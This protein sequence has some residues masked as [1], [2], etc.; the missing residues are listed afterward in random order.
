MLCATATPERILFSRDKMIYGHFLEHFHRQVYGG[1]FMPGHPLSDKDG[2]RTDV[3]DALRKIQTPIIR[4]P[5]GCFVSSYHW[6][7]GVGK[8]I[9]VFD[10]AW[11]V[12][13]DNSFG[14]DEFILLCRKI[15]CEPYICTNAGSGNEE[16]MSNWM[17]YCNLDNQGEYAKQR[18][19]NGHREPYN[20][21]YWSVGNENY[22]DWE[23]GAKSSAEWG[24]FVLESTKM[25]KRIDP[26]AQLSAAALSDID[27]NTHLLEKAGSRLDWISIHGYWDGLWQNDNP[28]NYEQSMAYTDS[29]DGSIRRVRGLLTAFGLEKRIRIAYDEWNL[30]GWHHPNAHTIIPGVTK[31]EYL[32]PR[33]RNDLNQTYTMSDAVFSAC[34]FNTLLRNA[35]IVG[36]ANFAPMIN[37]RGGI[38]TYDKGIV[39]RSTYHVFD[40]YVNH[41]YDQIIDL[42][43]TDNPIYQVKNKSGYT[44]NV[45]MID[46]VATR[47]SSSGKLAISLI[48]KHQ[49][50]SEKVL[51]K[52][53][54]QNK[55]MRLISLTGR[56]ADDYNDIDRNY[57]IP[58]ENNDAINK[59]DENSVEL[60][61]PAHSVNI[62]EIG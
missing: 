24:R 31:E 37:T 14:T 11:R 38:F 25:M 23:M 52:L 57:V 19:A 26:T 27:W 32:Y 3:L 47:D 56:S 54:I 30:R 7:K 13:D 42:Y 43:V 60:T 4:W 21:K 59:V 8:R 39:L 51:L 35:D 6:E 1:I 17:E 33:D 44:T 9:H 18:I 61:L 16:E 45:D 50:S 22:G 2:F 55:S 28:A 10:K 5:G 12:E 20:V 15:G 58:F 41:M 46:I 34:F 40:M 49:S 62:L 36:M 29:L 48:N 53:P